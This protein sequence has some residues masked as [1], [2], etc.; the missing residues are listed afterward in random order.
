[1]VAEA[2]RAGKRYAAAMTIATHD[3][4]ARLEWAG[5]T[6]TGTARY[7][8]YGR[9]FVVHVAGKPPLAATA[10]PRF[11]G[12]A[13]TH[14]PEELLLAAV[15]GCHMLTYLALCARGGVR[16]VAYADDV[17]GSVRFAADGG[18]FDGIVL[19]P[20]VT[21]DDDACVAA[22]LA[23]HADAHARCV[24]ARSCAVPIRIDPHVEV[25]PPCTT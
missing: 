13:D 16:V 12:A 7:A 4:E 8:G 20:R 19:R 17:R 5:N 9:Q 10:D 25:T 15:A 22:A 24:I 2:W 11:R 23:L 3:Y 6:G 21:V 18:A 14:N 1:M